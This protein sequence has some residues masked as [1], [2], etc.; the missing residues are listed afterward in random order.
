MINLE[1]IARVAH[2]TGHQGD[3]TKLL[4]F[5]DWAKVTPEQL[6]QKIG[7][8]GRPGTL[9]G[10]NEVY[11]Y[12]SEPQREIKKDKA[13]TKVEKVEKKDPIP[14]KII[15]VHVQKVSV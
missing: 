2:F 15:Q 9:E 1:K 13:S 5:D 8:L 7:R 6:Q 12:S 4:E 10:K 3:P 14:Y 11:F